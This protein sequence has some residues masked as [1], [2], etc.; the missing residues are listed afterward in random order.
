MQA[1]RERRG[2]YMESSFLSDDQPKKRRWQ[3]CDSPAI[4]L[5][6]SALADIDLGT[7]CL[8]ATETSGRAKLGPIDFKNN[9]K[10]F[11]RDRWSAS[12]R[13]NFLWK[14]MNF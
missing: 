11:Q 4:P 3:R 14:L 9:T 1:K 8:N 10:N 2:S 13:F 7:A 5:E 12:L 6:C